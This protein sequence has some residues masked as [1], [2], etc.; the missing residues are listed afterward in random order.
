MKSSKKQLKNFYVCVWMFA[1]MYVC[2]PHGYLVPV[3][4]QNGY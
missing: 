3:E 2:A 1:Y 4:A